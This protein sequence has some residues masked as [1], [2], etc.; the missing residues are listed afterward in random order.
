MITTRTMLLAILFASLATASSAREITSFVEPYRDID[1]SSPEMDTIS[2]IHVREGDRVSSG[3][4]LAVLNEEVL[5]AT[6]T[7]ARKAKEAQG[8]LLSAEAELQLQSDLLEKLRGLFRR[9]HSTNGE[10]TRAE[11]QLD[12]VSARVRAVRDE[13]DVKAADFDRIKAQLEQKRIK[14]PIDGIVTHIYKDS[15][16]FVSATEPV[17]LKVVQLNPLLVV[18]SV[19]SVDA[20]QLAADLE[21]PLAI[22]KRRVSTTGVIEFV[23]PT[24]DA[25]S[26]TVRVKVRI[27]NSK[28]EFRSGDACWLQLDGKDREEITRYTSGSESSKLRSRGGPSDPIRIR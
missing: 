8:K 16:E 26:G 14:S 20:E 24:T 22:G 21:V 2:K 5:Q 19:P 13:M 10:I 27:P 28:G 4:V 9:N 1:V 3:Q 17:I 18:F 15:G 23:S 11:A 7:V 6:L 25:Q 12:I